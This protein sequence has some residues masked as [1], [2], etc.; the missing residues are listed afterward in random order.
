MISKL[1]RLLSGG[2]VTWDRLLVTDGLS[3]EA[4]EQITAVSPAA[5]DRVWV[6]IDHDTPAGSVAVAEKQKALLDWARLTGVVNGYSDEQFGPNDPV[7]REQIA[8]VFWRTAGSPEAAGGEA[9]SDGDAISA[10]AV[11]AVAWARGNGLINGREGNRFVPQDGATRAEVATILMR[12]LE[13]KAKN[14]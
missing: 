12:L 11:D 1:E 4:V 13:S 9:F 5:P 8:T 7:S 6:V 2:T 3:P 10:W 14:A